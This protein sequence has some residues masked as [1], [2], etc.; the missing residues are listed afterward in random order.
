MNLYSYIVRYDHGFS[1][2][3]QGD[4]CTLA[5]CK[6]I[7][8]RVAQPGDW[9][10]G[11]TPKKKGAG[12]LVYLMKVEQDLTFED[13]YRNRAWRGRADNIYTPTKAGG[14]KQRTNPYHDRGNCK[15]DLSV[16]RVLLSRR[17]IYL[18]RQAAEIHKTFRELICAGQGHRVFGS[19]T[20]HEYA[21]QEERLI[22]ALERWAFRRWA[23]KGGAAADRPTLHKSC[24]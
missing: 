12:K 3:P 10:L 9:I 8:R 11:T 18:G 21:S 15:K 5:C 20:K 7:I 2:C 19:R 22:G 6:P 1:P 24:R 16:D 23:G 13:Y 4:T 17:F 14:Y